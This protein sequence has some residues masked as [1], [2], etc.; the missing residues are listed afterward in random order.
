M[1]GFELSKVTNSEVYFPNT[2]WKFYSCE[3]SLNLIS[4][5]VIIFSF[6]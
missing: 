2:E 6:S 1:I 5:F 4:E 3:I